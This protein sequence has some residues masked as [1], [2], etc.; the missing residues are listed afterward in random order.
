MPLDLIVADEPVSKEVLDLEGVE[1]FLVPHHPHP[2]RLLLLRYQRSRGSLL[3][4]A[5]LGDQEAH[6]P[7]QPIQ[8][9]ELEQEGQPEG[10]LE[11]GPL[12][13]DVPRGRRMADKLVLGYHYLLAEVAPAALVVELMHY[14]VVL[15]VGIDWEHLIDDVS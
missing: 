9:G 2:H 4:Y 6:L 3:E 10:F 13:L 12:G 11:T 8:G 5:H 1:L 15:D 14:L 7:G